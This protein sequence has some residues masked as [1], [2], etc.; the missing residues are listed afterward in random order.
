MGQAPLAGAAC[1]G[2]LPMMRLLL[3]HGADVEGALPEGKTALMKAA[4]FYRVAIIEQLL[5]SSARRHA[6][7]AG[8]VRALDAATRTGAADSA[9]RLEVHGA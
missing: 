7:D 5:A 1:K 2:D 9:A 4:M 6:R 8:G 3:N